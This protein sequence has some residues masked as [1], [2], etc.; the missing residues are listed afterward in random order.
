MD[1]PFSSQIKVRSYDLDSFGHVNNAV[2]LNY[3]EAARC[4]YL[5]Q[6]GL[7]FNSFHKWGA[8]PFV[9]KAEIS[10][11]APARCD[12]LLD[13]RGA[14]TRMKKSS[15]TIQYEIFNISQQ[16]VCA[17]AEMLFAFLNDQEKIIPMPDE[18]REKMC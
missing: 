11:K 9:V 17:M 12:D 5:E 15:F 10:Y 14:L 6:R 2:Y 7:N 1:Y 16:K 3:L 13:I 18:F 4:D 8:F